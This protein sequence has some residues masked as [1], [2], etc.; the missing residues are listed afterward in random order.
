ME[1]ISVGN[2]GAL[3]LIVGPVLAFVAFL[4][5]P[6]GLLID[7]AAVTDGAGQIAAAVSN[8]AL[9][10]WTAMFVAVGLILTL[11]GLH[12]LQAGGSGDTHNLTQVAFF[13]IVIGSI[14]W[15]L[16]Q[17]MMFI[18]A[19][20][21]GAES[22][23]PVKSALTFIGAIP[24]AAGLAIHSYA[25]SDRDDW[26]RILAWIVTVASLVALVAYAVGI[27]DNAQ[28][29]DMITIARVCYVAWVVWFVV[30]GLG[31][32]KGASAE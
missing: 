30:L 7:N 28:T 2:L 13:M 15:V 9:A 1:K 10:N 11:Y 19:D 25:L 31:Q 22:A 26:T 23:Y 12:T 3:A 8:D 14:G 18:M 29:D 20:G 5:Q 32:L 27:L 16:S 17:G 6:G 21:A 24:L 4:V